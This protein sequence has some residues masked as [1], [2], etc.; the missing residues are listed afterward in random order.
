MSLRTPQI[1]QTDFEPWPLGRGL[2]TWTS[3][4]IVDLGGIVMAVGG[5]FHTV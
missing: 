2:W 3:D 1:A 5:H 4:V